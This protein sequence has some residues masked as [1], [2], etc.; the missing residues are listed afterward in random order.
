MEH[1]I[2][3]LN[4]RE[5]LNIYMSPVRQELLRVLRLSKTPMTP[6]GLADRLCISPSSVQHH[7][8]K[9]LSLGV[10]EVDHQEV[11]NGIT[12]TYYRES[13]ATVRIG[14]E[15]GDELR[16]ERETMVTHLVNRVLQGFLKLVR[17]APK[18]SPVEELARHGMLT[19]G[20]VRL[21]PKER[22][23]LMELVNNFLLNHDVATPEQTECWECVVLAYQPEEVL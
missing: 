17:S 3:H 9:L 20:V 5:E 19:S 15:R 11:I 8:K 12:A 6:K 4:T 14:L 16:E 2:V 18:D 23:E 10:V 7:L 21:S 22:E 13:F 1:N